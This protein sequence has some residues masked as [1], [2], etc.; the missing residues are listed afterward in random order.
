[1]RI[2]EDYIF[3]ERIY[4]KQILL[5]RDKVT[6]RQ[7]ELNMLASHYIENGKSVDYTKSHLLAF[8]KKRMSGDIESIN[9]FNKSIPAWNK[10]ILI[11]TRFAQTNKLKEYDFVTISKA[12]I[13]LIKSE[14][15]IRKQNA[16]F[17]LIYLSKFNRLVLDKGEHRTTYVITD[18]YKV[19]QSRDTIAFLCGAKNVTR[20]LTHF[21]QKGLIKRIK[22]YYE[23]LCINNEDEEMKIKC[24]DELIEQ[25]NTYLRENG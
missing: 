18:K 3:D 7:N 1:M 9:K 8:V 19:T 14:K 23:V 22:G 21:E 2:R 16:L 17:I 15:S 10:K 20:V 24:N 5:S 25:L 12:E 13:E 11:A 6:P 4:A